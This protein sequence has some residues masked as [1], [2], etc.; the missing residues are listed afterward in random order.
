MAKGEIVE[1]EDEVEEDARPN[2]RRRGGRKRLESA[3]ISG[4]TVVGAAAVTFIVADPK[5]EK[6]VQDQLVK[7]P[8]IDSEIKARNTAGLGALLGGIGLGIAGFYVRSGG[9]S[10]PILGEA[11]IGAGA[12]LGVSGAVQLNVASK[13]KTARRVMA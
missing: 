3:A 9:R 4:A 11:L 5:V 12:G 6:W 2:P 7:T 1:L 8:G 13:L 10:V